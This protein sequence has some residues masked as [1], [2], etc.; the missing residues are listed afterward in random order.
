[1]TSSFS[2]SV[3]R[4]TDIFVEML[5]KL[6]A[7]TT[8]PTRAYLG[9]STPVPTLLPLVASLAFRLHLLHPEHYP[10]IRKLETGEL[11]I[12]MTESKLMNVE[13]LR[14]LSLSEWPHDYE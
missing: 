4:L 13:A 3:S 12:S 5:T 6:K 7:S 10:K 8:Q 14:R 2:G 9:S 1:M 11:G